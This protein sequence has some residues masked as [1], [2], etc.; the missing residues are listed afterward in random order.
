MPGTMLEGSLAACEVLLGAAKSL[1][2]LSHLRARTVPLSLAFVCTS[3]MHSGGQKG[4][5]EQDLTFLFALLCV[6]GSSD[7]V[8]FCITIRSELAEGAPA[9]A[10]TWAG[11][12]NKES[13]DSRAMEIS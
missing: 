12:V 8:R 9:V 1:L 3:C 2:D 10:G 5:E 13:L 7:Y 11:A 4:W 6:T